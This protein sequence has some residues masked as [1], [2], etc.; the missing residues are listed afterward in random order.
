MT[1]A[2]LLRLEALTEAAETCRGVAMFP[3][4]TDP[5]AVCE[6]C[7]LAIEALRDGTPWPP[8]EP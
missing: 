7:A 3:G 5:V 2:Q 8:F 6:N 4:A 1:E